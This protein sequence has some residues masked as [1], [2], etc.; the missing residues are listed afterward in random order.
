MLC[1]LI[2]AEQHSAHSERGRAA[3]EKDAGLDIG[4]FAMG[5]AIV[6]GSQTDLG[7]AVIV[8]DGGMER[9]TVSPHPEAFPG[10]EEKQVEEQQHE[11]GSGR[12]A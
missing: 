3:F 11:Y 7:W 12:R 9:K 10:D 8:E 5:E 2:G 4:E 1:C 6:K